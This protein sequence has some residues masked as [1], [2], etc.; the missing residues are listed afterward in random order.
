MDP[1]RERRLA[2][3]DT[4]EQHPVEGE[5]HG[6]LD[7]DRQAAGDR[8]DLLAL[9]QLHHRAAELLA[10]VLVGLLQVLDARLHGLHLRHRAA[11]R[12]RQR[13]E[14]ELQQEGDQDDRNAPVAG[15]RVHLVEHPEQRHRQEPQPAVIRHPAELGGGRL[16]LPLQ[17]WSD[18][19][20]RAE[21]RRC[22]GRDRLLRTRGRQQVLIPGDTQ[23][24]AP[25]GAARRHDGADEVVLQGGEP[26]VAHFEGQVTVLRVGGVELAILG[27][28]VNRRTVERVTLD[29]EHRALGGR[30]IAQ[31]LRVRARSPGRAAAVVDL[32]LHVDAVLAAV[33]HEGLG[34]RHCALTPGER[35]AQL[36]AAIEAVLGL[37]AREGREMGGIRRGARLGQ[38]RLQLVARQRIV[39]VL[40]AH[41]RGL[42][43]HL[44]IGGQ[45]HPR[46]R[47]AT[48]AD[49]EVEYVR[50]HVHA[51]RRGAGAGRRA[52]GAR[53]GRRPGFTVGALT[54]GGCRGPGCL[55]NPGAEI[56]RW[57]SCVRGR[58]QRRRGRRLRRRPVV[59]QPG[60]VVDQQQRRERDPQPQ[61][62]AEAREVIAHERDRCTGAQA[63][64]GRIHPGATGGSAT[65]AQA[66]A[67][68]PS[69][70]RSA[71]APARRTA[72]RR[73]R[74]GTP[75]RATD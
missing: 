49:V 40:Q 4:L 50:A 5:E 47:A 54:R 43:L 19:E 25:G 16:E 57:R 35:H 53:G 68:R 28:V 61:A 60:L 11:A 26:A 56:V 71:A 31:D 51:G 24:E 65:G 21:L 37:R 73:D 75:A 27:A 12:L 33:E 64:R 10:V 34:D 38:T 8:V 55:G 74:N 23:R 18:V 45:I 46:E 13:V 69:R 66:R 15:E 63:A 1:E 36:V 41:P 59:V 9:I 3:L 58:A 72:S 32:V 7:H 22:A 48:R 14:H 70:P 44:R 20:R 2:H 30:I 52:G 39:L 29:I 67:S 42:A 62:R 6:D 17:L